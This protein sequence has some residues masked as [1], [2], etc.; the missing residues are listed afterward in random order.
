M[1]KKKWA[2]GQPRTQHCIG[3]CKRQAGMSVLCIH[4]SAGVVGGLPEG[5][6]LMAMVMRNGSVKQPM[7]H[8]NGLALHVD[9]QSKSLSVKLV[10]N[11]HDDVEGGVQ[12]NHVVLT[13]GLLW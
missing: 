4:A 13:E 8:Q 11:T 12:T 1:N 2:D 3:D 9:D 10:A 6:C 7:A 5:R